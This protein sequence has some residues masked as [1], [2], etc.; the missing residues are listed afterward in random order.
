MPAPRR[1]RGSLAHQT[2]QGILELCQLY[3]QL[4]FFR[5]GPPRK[6]IENQRRPVYYFMPR[7]SSDSVPQWGKLIV[8]DRRSASA[9]A[10]SRDRSCALPC[11]CKAAVP[12]SVLYLTGDNLRAGSF[13]K[14]RQLRHG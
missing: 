10:A 7:T 14:P 6:D 8:N 5:F 9:A 4:S 11:R 13:R 2:G 1:E 12:R 3:L